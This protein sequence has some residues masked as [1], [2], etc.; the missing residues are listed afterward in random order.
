M[1]PPNETAGH[2]DPHRNTRP[3]VSAACRG[4]THR[5]QYAR[6]CTVRQAPSTFGLTP[7]E[8]WHEAARLVCDWGWSLDEVRE[9]LELPE[10]VAS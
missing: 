4:F 8:L 10:A 3:T 6:R 2:R 1:S 5:S 7:L 9:V